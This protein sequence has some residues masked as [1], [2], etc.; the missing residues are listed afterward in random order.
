MTRL[1]KVYRDTDAVIQ[2]DLK[3]HGRD[4]PCGKGCDTC[5]HNACI[6]ISKPEITGIIEHI[7]NDIDDE[8]LER[9]E[10]ELKRS[11]ENPEKCPFLVDT[12]C[13]IYAVRPL[14]CR[15]FLIHGKACEPGEDISKGRM[16]DLHRL[17]KEELF[18]AARPLLELYGLETEEQQREAFGNGFL[19]DQTVPM[20]YYD[21]SANLLSIIE[22][23]KV[24]LGI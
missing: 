18:Q 4:I 9:I 19:V 13:G 20:H 23:K 24:Y 2:K 6:P 1:L 7:K 22:A 21:W 12:E 11:A 8:M 3:E 5:C 15:T 10:T 17:P 16:D 14:A